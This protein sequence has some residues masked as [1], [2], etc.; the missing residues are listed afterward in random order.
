VEQECLVCSG[1]GWKMV[2]RDGASAAEPCECRT[3]A[4]AARIESAANIP[5]HYLAADFDNFLAYN[6]RL[7]NVQVIARRYAAEYPPAKGP[8]GLL[9]VGDTGSGKT[10]LAIAVMRHLIAAGHEC[11]FFDYQGLLERIRSGYDPASGS[12]SREAYRTALECEVLVLD[13]IGAHRVTDWVEDTI[14]SIITQRCNENR[15]LIATTNLRDPEAGDPPVP[16]GLA[17]DVNS[18]YYLAERIG[19]RAR[20][21]LFE[22]CRVVSTR[23]VDDY[24][25]RRGR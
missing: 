22:M 9:F 18:R 6:D 25:T 13:D 1:T 16:Q 10:H 19:F 14:T 4:R 15:A 17:G 7:Q 21:R 20:S 2:T 3:A 12:A 8:R 24:R 23:G 11:V 5:P